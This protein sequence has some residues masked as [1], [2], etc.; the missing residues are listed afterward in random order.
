MNSASLASDVPPGLTARKMISSCL[1]VV[2][3]STTRTPFDNVHSVMPSVSVVVVFGDR[4]SRRARRQQRLALT[5]STYAVR[6]SASVPLID[7]RRQ[8]ASFG[9]VGLSASGRRYGHEAIA[10]GHPVFGQRVHFGQRDFRQEALVQ[11]VLV[12]DAGDRL[13]L[14][15]VADEL[16]G[17]RPRRALVLLDDARAR[18]SAAG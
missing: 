1:Y 2:G 8:L 12:D 15:E 4:A 11:A 6:R 14:D 10:I 7:R 9:N 13:V 18:G 5:V 16:V 17:E 3:L